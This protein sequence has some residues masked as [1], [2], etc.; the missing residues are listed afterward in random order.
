MLRAADVRNWHISDELAR[1]SNVWNRPESRSR[2]APLYWVLTLV[3]TNDGRL[4]VGPEPVEGGKPRRA[5]TEGKARAARADSKQ[6]RMIALMQRPQGMT[7]DDAC[8]AFDWQ[9][10]TVRGAIAGA[11]KGKLGLNINVEEAE[12]R[13]VYRIAA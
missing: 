6:A 4:A 8:K 10:H 9:R 12:G 3:I 2:R 5:K 1:A 11:L 13:R 7:L